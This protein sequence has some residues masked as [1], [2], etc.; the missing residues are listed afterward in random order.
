[1]QLGSRQIETKSKGDILRLVIGS[2]H[3]G[4]ILKEELKEKLSEEV[5]KLLMLVPTMTK[6]QLI[7]PIMLRPWA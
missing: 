7:T 3:A 1:M 6:N 4:F 5:M 2:D